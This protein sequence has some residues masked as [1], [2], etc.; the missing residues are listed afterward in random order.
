V[1]AAT[2][3]VAGALVLAL[4]TAAPGSAAA[5]PALQ[6]VVQDDAQLLH[7]PTEQVVASL[8]QLKALGVD[9]LRVTASWSSL[10]RDADQDRVPPAFDQTDPAA[11]EQSRWAVLDRLVRLSSQRGLDIMLDI[12]FWAPHWATDDQPGP[13]ARTD[14]DVDAYGRFASAVARRYNGSFTP[15]PTIEALP[16]S[17]DESF[18]DQLF[19]RPAPPPPATAPDEGPLPRVKIF[20]V[21][22]EPNHPAFLLPQLDGTKPVSPGVYRRMVAAA[23]TA[24]KGAQGDARVLIGGL[25][26]K[27]AGRKGV[28]PLRFVRDLA[29]VDARLRPRTDGDCAGFTKVPGDGFTMHPYSLH[30]PPDARP[31]KSQPDDVPLGALDNLTQLLDRLAA[32]GRI[33]P[34]VRNVWITEYGYET[35]PPSDD[36]RYGLADQAKFLPWAEYLAWR[37]PRVVAHSQFLLRDLP[38]AATRQSASERR[39]FGQWLSGIQFA[40]GRA[41]PAQA[42]FA[43]GVFV[44]PLGGPRARTSGVFGRI[45]PGRGARQ[46]ELQVRR[47]SGRWRALRSGPSARG[48]RV[49]RFRTRP[50]GT[51][52]RVVARSSV[53]RGARVRAR[54]RNGSS[55]EWTAGPPAAPI[56]RPS[57]LG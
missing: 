16:P 26:S 39:G 13:R 1:G 28:A 56:T 55:G 45:R 44:R 47:G 20:G 54:W 21:W 51:F 30:T 6:T 29:C 32:R 27:D 17:Q 7:T 53:V 11:Y 52:D 4:V 48:K 35:N 8:D 14:L 50:D 24:I 15:P 22:N 5:R 36:A 33:A 18:L 10:T 25:A 37:N 23:H 49:V 41:K 34:G 57:P 12:A 42:A 19:G 31:S 43:A 40:D 38:P 2:T 9:T 46:V 3:A